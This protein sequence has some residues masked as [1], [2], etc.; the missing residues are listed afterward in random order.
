MSLAVSNL[1]IWVI[2]V[3]GLFMYLEDLTN[4]KNLRA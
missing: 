3:F 1:S 4:A 2:Y